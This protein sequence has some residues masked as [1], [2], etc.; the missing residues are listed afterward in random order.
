MTT[1]VNK[2][3][4]KMQIFYLQFTQK[5]I[6]GLRY[7]L[8]PRSQAKFCIDSAEQFLTTP[9]F[10]R[11][12][13]KNFSDTTALLNVAMCVWPQTWTQWETANAKSS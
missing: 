8:L 10:E 3:D 12:P 13:R 9:A 5:Y 6:V 7:F 2:L 1:K 4:A 11:A